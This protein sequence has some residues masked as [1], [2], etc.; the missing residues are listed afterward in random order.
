MGEDEVL[1]VGGKNE[2]Q[3]DLTS[4]EIIS[5]SSSTIRKGP[6][7]NHP[8]SEFGLVSEG[9]QVPIILAIG[10]NSNGVKF[11]SIE[12]LREDKKTWDLMPFSL[13]E[14]KSNFGYLVIPPEVLDH[15]YKGKQH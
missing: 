2:N 3:Q 6:E 1:I 8:R 5:L 9:F 4:T 12:Y 7:L 13:S 11:E 14:G 15:K 10:G